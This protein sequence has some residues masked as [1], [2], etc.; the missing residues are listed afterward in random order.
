MIGI[1]WKSANEEF[2]SYKTLSLRAWDGILRV[3][4][5]RFID[6]QYGDTG[7]ERAAVEREIGVAIEHLPELDLYDDLEG[8]AALCSACDLVITASNVTA[9]VAGALGCPVWLIA[10][11]GNGAPEPQRDSGV[12][13]PRAKNRQKGGDSGTIRDC[14]PAAL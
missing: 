7:S 14:R 5:A 3:P 12:P 4:G 2:G 13:V 8:L 11:R 9:H 1:S 10:P 6:L